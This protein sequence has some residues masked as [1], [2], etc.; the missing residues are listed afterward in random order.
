MLKG[1]LQGDLGPALEISVLNAG[2]ALYCANV[3]PNIEQ[4]ITLARTA[5]ESGAAATKLTQLV[6][7]SQRLAA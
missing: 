5:V 4:G 6:A 7:V 1:V 2:V 3:V